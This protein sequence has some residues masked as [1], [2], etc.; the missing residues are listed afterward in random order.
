MEPVRLTDTREA[1]ALQGGS[2]LEVMVA[3]AGGVPADAIAVVLNVAAAQPDGA[4]FL[5]RVSM[6]RDCADRSNV[7]YL[8]GQT[9]ANSVTTQIG[10]DGKVCIFAQTTTHIVVDVSGVY[11]PSGTSLQQILIPQRIRDTR[12]SAKVEGGQ[13]F[14]VQIT[15]QAN[16]PAN[17][18]AALLNLTVTDA[19]AD[20]YLTVY[21]CGLTPPMASNVNYGPGRTIANAVAATIGADG[22]VCIYLQSTAHVLIDL[23]G[24]LVP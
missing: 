12:E 16:V 13:V 17:A 6:W 8:G 10:P 3:G 5:D 22:K 14:E 7:N 15:G 2:A 9:V 1:A 21:P 23:G 20:G 24:Y 19:D 11:A 18:T 4:G